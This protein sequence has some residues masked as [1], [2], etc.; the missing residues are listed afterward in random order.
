MPPKKKLTSSRTTTTRTTA[1]NGLKA[2]SKSKGTTAINDTNDLSILSN[3]STIRKHTSKISSLLSRSRRSNVS[4]FMSSQSVDDLE[5]DDGFLFKRAGKPLLNK[6]NLLGSI[7]EPGESD[8]DD[9]DDDYDN[10]N[11]NNNDN[12]KSFLVPVKS[13]PKKKRR[14]SSIVLENQ[15]KQRKK[16]RNN[17]NNSIIAPRTSPR[18]PH[19]SAKILKAVKTKSKLL[20]IESESDRNDEFDLE[21]TVESMTEMTRTILKGKKRTSLRPKA[22]SQPTKTELL[23]S[24][25]EN[26]ADSPPVV[27]PK[28]SKAKTAKKQVT[29][30]KKST[31]TKNESQKKQPAGAIKS[32]TTTTIIIPKNKINNKELKKSETISNVP[33]D[34]E[35]TAKTNLSQPSTKVYGSPGKKQPL[36]ISE[37]PVH[38]RNKELRAK[39]NRRSSLGNR[40]KRTSSIGN[41][42]EVSPH[43]DVLPS[44][45]YKHLDQDLPEPHR[46]RQLLT[47]CFKRQFEIDKSKSKQQKA[48]KLSNEDLIA[49]NIAKVIKEEIIRDLVEGKVKTSWWNRDE[50]DDEEGPDDNTKIKKKV[51]I[52]PNKQNVENLKT[53]KT[54]DARIAKLKKE[55]EQ[56]D[57]IA[58]DYETFQPGDEIK[59]DENDDEK[60][61]FLKKKIDELRSS[62][63]ERN[64]AEEMERLYSSIMDDKNL[65][66]MYDKVSLITDEVQASYESSLNNFS[67]FVDKLNFNDSIIKSF[68]HNKKKHISNI[69]RK[70]IKTTSIEDADKE[71]DD[72]EYQFD[73]IELLKGI[74]RIDKA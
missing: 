25:P 34:L 64:E 15:P 47:W 59:L 23:I 68:E 24:I 29:K 22:K 26:K 69:I 17:N 9:D 44:N 33:T 61:E 42:F 5:N 32:K 70:Y 58:A 67:T 16:M 3:S 71:E 53:L 52:V 8:T 55:N 40:G 27:S 20:D 38:R 49:E 54:F 39:S 10:N 72:E 66:E 45:F 62:T 65:D 57:K 35:L 73:D 56:W 11:N 60:K 4:S 19:P 28:S 51:K 30:E 46:M 31:K 18:K 21:D 1:R 12:K 6:S 37:S 14:S 41:G 43:D 48:K 50:D 2:S 74:T 36:Q 63:K 7:A 13:L